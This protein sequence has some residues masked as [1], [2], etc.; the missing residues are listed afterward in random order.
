ML[1]D[2]TKKWTKKN[3]KRNIYD[4]VVDTKVRKLT[5]SLAKWYV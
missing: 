5:Q 2:V 3:K 1:H 4:M